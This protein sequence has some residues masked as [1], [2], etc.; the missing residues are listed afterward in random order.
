MTQ[1]EEKA[2]VAPKA[3]APAAPPVAKSLLGTKA[4]NQDDFDK[5]A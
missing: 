4:K 5:Y 2:V 3:P 1:N